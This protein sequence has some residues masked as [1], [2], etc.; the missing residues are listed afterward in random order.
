MT[1]LGKPFDV[2]CG[3]GLFS[4]GIGQCDVAYMVNPGIGISYR[5]QPYKSSHPIPIDQIIAYDKLLRSAI[6][7]ALVRDYPWPE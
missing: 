7:R 6:D 1:P 2:N 4:S 5:F 3:P